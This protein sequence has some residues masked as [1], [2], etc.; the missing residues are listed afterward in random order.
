MHLSQTDHDALTALFQNAY[1]WAQG[2]E[3][4]YIAQGYDQNHK[5]VE[6]IVPCAAI[7]DF[8]PKLLE[9]MD[10]LSY[11]YER[12]E[13]KDH[14]PREAV[15]ATLDYIQHGG[16]EMMSTDYRPVTLFGIQSMYTA[17]WNENILDIRGMAVHTQTGRGPYQGVV[18]ALSRY[19]AYPSVHKSDLEKRFPG[20]EQRWKIA[21]ELG[22]DMPDL[23]K[24]VFC[25]NPTSTPVR[26]A[27]MGDVTFHYV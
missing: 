16:I 25:T 2:Q 9:A 12:Q 11:W 8:H 5:S 23:V 20:W 27:S 14:I 7:D 15:I 13:K 10:A 24:H 1:K 21:S 4:T 19:N 18:F 26:G 3:E 6:H 22:V 17:N